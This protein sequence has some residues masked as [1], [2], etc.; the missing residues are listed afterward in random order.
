MNCGQYIEKKKQR[1]L[2]INTASPNPRRDL[3]AE[4]SKE[5]T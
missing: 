4:N 2:A 3:E 1:I 5:H